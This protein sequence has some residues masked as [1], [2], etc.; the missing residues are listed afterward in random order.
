MA[1]RPSFGNVDETNDSLRFKRKCAFGITSSNM[2]RLHDSLLLTSLLA[3]HRTL[4]SDG[5]LQKIY[6]RLEEGKRTLM[7]GPETV[8]FD[9]DGILFALTEE[10]NL[11]SLTDFEKES[12]T[13]ITAKTTLVA[14]LGF[15][16]P[17]GGKFAPDGTLYIA[18]AVLGLTRIKNPRDPKSKLE[19]V[20]S[21]VMDAGEETRIFFADDVV[22]GPKTGMVYFTDGTL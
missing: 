8:L 19:I 4:L 18:D 12:D 13:K 1:S 21:T 20:A 14:N 15:G 9:N 11:V 17:L 16:R 6:E 7:R 22:I 5:K 10:A 2:I 3:H